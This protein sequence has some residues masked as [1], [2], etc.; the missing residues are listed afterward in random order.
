MF[1]YYD[2][3]KKVENP[4]TLLSALRRNAEAVAANK[5]QPEAKFMFWTQVNGCGIAKSCRIAEQKQGYLP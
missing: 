4:F 1:L 5:A 3:R 2:T